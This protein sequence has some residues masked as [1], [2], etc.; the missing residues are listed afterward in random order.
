M[1]DYRNFTKRNVLQGLA[2][3]IAALGVGGA[4]KDTYDSISVELNFEYD[5]FPIE[6]G[7]EIASNNPESDYTESVGIVG[8]KYH[9][10]VPE[11]GSYTIELEDKGESWEREFEVTDENQ[12]FNFELE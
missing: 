3:G 1:S 12:E 4:I 7:A 5:N 10:S 8:Q 11:K 2:G 6:G 9:A